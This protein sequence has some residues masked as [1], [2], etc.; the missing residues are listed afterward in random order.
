[1]ML[2]WQNRPSKDH[3]KYL[4]QKIFEFHILEKYAYLVVDKKK[5]GYLDTLNFNAVSQNDSSRIGNA[6]Y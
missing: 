6:A 4:Q 3:L 2:S 1:M 5:P